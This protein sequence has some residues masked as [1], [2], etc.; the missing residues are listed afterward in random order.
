MKATL[1]AVSGSSDWTM[2]GSDLNKLIIECPDAVCHV[3]D[4]ITGEYITSFQNG[5]E[6][7]AV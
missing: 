4:N 1:K 3:Y 6:Y 7:E 2:A 5:H